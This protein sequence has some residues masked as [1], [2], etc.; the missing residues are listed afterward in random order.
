M[1]IFPASIHCSQVYVSCPLFGR[2]NEAPRTL[3]RG[4]SFLSART[5]RKSAHP[6]LFVPR[7]HTVRPPPTVQNSAALLSPPNFPRTTAFSIFSINPNDHQPNPSIAQRVILRR[8]TI[9]KLYTP[10]QPDSACAIESSRV[11]QRA[12]IDRIEV[13]LYLQQRPPIV[14]THL[15]IAPAP[16]LYHIIVC[17]S[18]TSS[19]PF[20][21]A[22]SIPSSNT[23]PIPSRRRIDRTSAA[24]A[25]SSTISTSAAIPGT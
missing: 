9:Q 19:L 18:S 22:L 4:R 12:H 21:I 13:V 15:I 7:P 24:T 3:A 16:F 6:H 1:H 23:I 5:G 8:P 10:Q 14:P 17:V 20:L 2:V 11:Q 25:F